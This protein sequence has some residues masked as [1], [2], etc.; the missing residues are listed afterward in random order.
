MEG[1]SPKEIMYGRKGGNWETDREPLTGWVDPWPDKGRA[2]VFVF[3]FVWGGDR[4]PEARETHENTSAPSS[5][6]YP[7]YNNRR[8][9][10]TLFF[11]SLTVFMCLGYMREASF[12]P[13]CLALHFQM[14]TFHRHSATAKYVN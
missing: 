13:G 11:C 10:E 6:L 2:A 8:A 9:G 4:G 3:I 7:P 5:S 14:P 12:A 1:G